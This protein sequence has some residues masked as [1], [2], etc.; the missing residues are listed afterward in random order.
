MNTGQVIENSDR[1]EARG[2]RGGWRTRMTAFSA[3]T[4]SRA[5]IVRVTYRRRDQ[6][7]EDR[8]QIDEADHD[9]DLGQVGDP[10]AGWVHYIQCHVADEIGGEGRSIVITVRGDD[11]RL[12]ALFAHEP[13]SF[14]E[15]AKT[16]WAKCARKPLIAVALELVAGRRNQQL[17]PHCPTSVIPITR[18]TDHFRTE[19][20]ITFT[21]TCI[22]AETLFEGSNGL[23]LFSSTLRGD[24]RLC[25]ALAVF[26][27]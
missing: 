12:D 16:R 9:R 19:W 25:D 13:A 24:R 15:F 10:R 1:N 7:I 3:A 5:S 18:T 17:P 22:H 27:G 4:A 20:P 8:C 14:F 2:L 21:G 6:A 11:K 26:G 23:R